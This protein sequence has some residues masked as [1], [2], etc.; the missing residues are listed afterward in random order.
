MKCESEPPLEPGPSRGSGFFV[1]SSIAKVT[2]PGAKRGVMTASTS[3]HGRQDP[4]GPSGEAGWYNLTL[5]YAKLS[6]MTFR[7]SSSVVFVHRSSTL[8]EDPPP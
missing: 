3:S 2:E 5:G 6:E 7:S 8:Q 1:V 4:A